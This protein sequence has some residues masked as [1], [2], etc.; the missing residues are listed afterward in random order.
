MT[1]FFFLFLAAATL[2]GAQPGFISDNA[3][4]AMADMP[5]GQPRKLLV[6]RGT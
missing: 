6:M 3:L 2:A 4:D 1:K 5:A